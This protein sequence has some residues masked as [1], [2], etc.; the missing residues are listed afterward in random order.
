MEQR[1]RVGVECPACHWK[2]FVDAEIDVSLLKSPIYQ[3]IK[4]H[5]EAWVRSHCPD[6][7]NAIANMSKN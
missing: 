5:L 3:E 1:V 6:H 2:Q 7:L 4:G